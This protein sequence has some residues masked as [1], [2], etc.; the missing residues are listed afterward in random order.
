M[1]GHVREK[2][3]RI[4]EAVRRGLEG[5]S[6]VEFIRQSGYAMSSAGIARHLRTMGGRGAVLELIEAGNT[7]AEVLHV[8]FPDVD[9]DELPH[10]P[11]SQT[12]LF[13]AERPS[14]GMAPLELQDTPL[15]ET[16]KM[17]ITV[18]A[19]LCEAIRLA[20]KGEGLSKSQLV[21]D[22]LTSALSNM[23]RRE[24]GAS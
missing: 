13:I 9:M 4:V 20:A 18:P 11:P 23:P 14:R 21:V 8:C 15:H 3:E 24:Q 17:T 22:I 7:N 19:D 6:A 12:E 10:E 5:D 2:Q 16:R 1:A